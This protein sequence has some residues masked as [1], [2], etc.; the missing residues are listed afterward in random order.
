MAG[1]DINITNN[2]FIKTPFEDEADN[3][4]PAFKKKR[5]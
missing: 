1:I 5:M 2:Y 3:D 4:G